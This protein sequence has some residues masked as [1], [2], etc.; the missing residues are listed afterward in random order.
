MNIDEKTGSTSCNT[1]CD[2]ANIDDHMTQKIVKLQPSDLQNEQQASSAPSS[3]GSSSISSSS[4]NQ[5][6]SG[7]HVVLAVEANAEAGCNE[8]HWNIKNDL[9]APGAGDSTS[10]SSNNLE[11][12]NE[13]KSASINTL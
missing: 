11:Y 7:R 1:D 12:V 13:A 8:N 4:N 10:S 3:T 5:I 9:G 2:L 6:Q